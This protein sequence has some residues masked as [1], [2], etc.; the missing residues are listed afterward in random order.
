MWEG[1]RALHSLFLLFFYSE[2][3][4]LINSY[5]QTTVV[6][7]GL[8]L[9]A[10]EQSIQTLQECLEKRGWCLVSLPS[11][12][13]SV[14]GNRSSI[15]LFMYLFKLNTDSCFDSMA[16]F[17][18]NEDRSYKKSFAVPCTTTACYGYYKDEADTKEGYRMLTG[19]M[20]Q[21]VMIPLAPLGPNLKAAAQSL[22]TLASNIVSVCGDKVFGILTVLFFYFFLYLCVLSFFF[23]F[24]LFD[25]F[26]IY[27]YY[28]PLVNCFV[29]YYFVCF[30]MV[31]ICCFFVFS[32]F[33]SNCFLSFF[34]KVRRFLP[35]AN[36]FL[37]KKK[38]THTQQGQIQGHQE[39]R[40]S[41]HC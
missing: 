2:C 37:K 20:W 29:I 39:K 18:S 32:L 25:G 1:K 22:D 40:K 23:V 30:V 31:Y 6:D 21:D 13:K 36:F 14:T 35:L 4:Q 19:P 41:Y 33:C 16:N 5:S 38:N 9:K 34:L 24:S 15:I 8:L 12:V 28:I 7:L 11:S 17:F 10:D 27:Y 3:H 26:V